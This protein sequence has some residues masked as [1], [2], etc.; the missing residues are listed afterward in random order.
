MTDV[1]CWSRKMRMV[2]SSEGT[3]A[4]TQCH[5]CVTP[6]GFTSQDRSL[7]VFWKPGASTCALTYDQV[8]SPLLIC[9]VCTVRV[10]SHL[11][12][13]SVHCISAN[14]TRNNHLHRSSTQ[15][16]A[17]LDLVGYEQLGRVHGEHSV[18]RGADD[19]AE[20]DGEVAQRIA[21]LKRAPHVELSGTTGSWGWEG[22]NPH[23]VSIQASL[24]NL[25]MQ[26]SL[27]LV[28]KTIHSRVRNTPGSYPLCAASDHS[29]KARVGCGSIVLHGAC[30]F[31]ETCAPLNT[32][33]AS[34]HQKLTSR[35]R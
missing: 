20:E 28:V 5:Q 19:D 12:S 6:I 34:L 26:C 27:R 3:A 2:L 31:V 17:Y 24:K 23:G 16:L 18:D 9:G 35:C 14:Q 22:S 32:G 29:F 25:F 33:E 21:D 4:T 11:S 1:I 13:R 15:A 8:N 7:R 30:D 10:L